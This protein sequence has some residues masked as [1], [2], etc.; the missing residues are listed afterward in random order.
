MKGFLIIS[1]S[2]T[3]F[4]APIINYC[5]D[6]KKGL[7]TQTSFTPAI[8]HCHSF[9]KVLETLTSSTPTNNYYY[10]LKEG[11]ETQ[12][13]SALINNYCYGLRKGLEIKLISTTF[14]LFVNNFNI[15]K[16]IFSNIEPAKIGYTFW[17]E[18]CW[19]FKIKDLI[20]ATYNLCKYIWKVILYMIL[21]SNRCLSS[22]I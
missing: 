10:G 8:N 9:R 5:H 14:T 17:R 15:T 3:T 20:L 11:L 6:L 21:T 7:K 4:F 13:F 2:Q 19:H 1:K 18:Y 16:N 12:I 22:D